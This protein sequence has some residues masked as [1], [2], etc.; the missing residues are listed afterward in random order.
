MFLLTFRIGEGAQLLDV[1][2]VD[3]HGGRVW[4]CVHTGTEVPEAD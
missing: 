3:R 1:S 2:A 4:D